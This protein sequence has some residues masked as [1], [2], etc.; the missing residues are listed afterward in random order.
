MVTVKFFGLFRLD[1]GLKTLELEGE[2]VKA[3]YPLIMAELRRTKPDCKLTE[4]DL[5]SCLPV[6]NGEKATKRTKLR[7]GDTVYFIPPAAGG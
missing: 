3:L 1:S 6:V 4:K 5:T 2:S 7:D